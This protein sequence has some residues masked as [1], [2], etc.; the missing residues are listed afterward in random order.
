MGRPSILIKE[1]THI[2]D[3]VIYLDFDIEIRGA[4]PQTIVKEEKS[5][6]DQTKRLGQTILLWKVALRIVCFASDQTPEALQVKLQKGLQFLTFP[7]KP[8]TFY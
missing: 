5:Y 6:I 1:G 2:V 3:E 8:P 7:L 4:G